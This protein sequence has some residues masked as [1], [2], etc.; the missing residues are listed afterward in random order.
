MNLNVG[1]ITLNGET[2]AQAPDPTVFITDRVRFGLYL[3]V[4]YKENSLIP[5]TG[6]IRRATTSGHSDMTSQD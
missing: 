2:W 5:A 1:S 4:V 6:I 3:P